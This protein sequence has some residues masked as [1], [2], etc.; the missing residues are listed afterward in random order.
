MFTFEYEAMDARAAMPARN[1]C[2]LFTS[3]CIHANI[4]GKR[5]FFE[6]KLFKMP[7]SCCAVGCTNRQTKENAKLHFYCI[8]KGKTPF[9]KRKRDDWIR[10]I[11][12]KNWP[13]EQIAK[14]RICSEHFVSGINLSF[15]SHLKGMW[16]LICVCS[17]RH[18][19]W[20]Y[21]K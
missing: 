10:A 2:S 16:Y 19:C 7:K 21:L 3:L 12:R 14:A 4:D 13:D 11:R 9:E 15:V 17:L 18:T 1:E 6:E 5:L 8:P 20:I